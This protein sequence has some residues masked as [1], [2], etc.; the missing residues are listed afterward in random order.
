MA[1]ALWWWG[2]APLSGPGEL[3][4][5]VLDV[6][7][8]DA[9]LVTTP[10]GAQVLIDGGRS[11]LVLTQELGAAMPHWDRKL[12][13]VVL[14]HPQEDHV[15]GLPEALK[16]F[17]VDAVYDDGADNDT[18][19]VRAFR[20]EAG[21]ITPL[22][23][24]DSFVVDRVT[25]RVLWPPGDRTEGGLNDR[26]LVILIEYGETR[27][28]LT[29]DIEGTAQRALMEAASIDADVLKVP[30]HGAATSL[31]A[32][33]DAVSPE[34]AVISAGEGNP[35]GHPRETT[36]TALAGAVTYRTDRD[37]RI[38][39]ASNGERLRVRTER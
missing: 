26:S 7:Q 3:E 16:R 31:A 39:V 33:F 29:G 12:E 20:E 30:H 15:A 21:A 11:G 24:G 17:R 19:A 6:G 9:I 38:V 23:E 35:F 1:V 25:F 5:A 37:G 13:A 34:V 22:F 10:R 32:F 8:G 2:F 4:M 27:F 36:L 18:D 14:T 28:L